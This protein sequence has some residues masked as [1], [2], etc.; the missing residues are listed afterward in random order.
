MVR[1]NGEV[2]RVLSRTLQTG[3][4]I[5]VAQPCEELG[6][7]PAPPL[8]TPILLYRDD[9]LVAGAKPAGTLSQPAEQ[10]PHEMSFDRQVLLYLALEDGRKPFLR[11]VHRLD[12]LTSG[13]VLFARRPEVLAILSRSWKEG[14]VERLYVAIVEGR[15]PFDATRID[16]PI[17]RDRAHSWRFQ[18]AE[19]GR[20]ARTEVTTLVPTDDGQCAV[21]C[22]LVTGRTHQVRVHLA[23]IGHPIVG[24]QLYGSARGEHAQRPLLHAVSLVLPHP[25]TGELLSIN[26]PPPEDIRSFFPEGFHVPTWKG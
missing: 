12:R 21:L 18:V 26:C 11:M 5:D 24:D 19:D 15:P 10:D 23:H 6:C 7:P 20:P 3:D 16:A 17:A 9:Y 22:R 4:V 14:R 13:A 25:A 1:R 8:E 2:L